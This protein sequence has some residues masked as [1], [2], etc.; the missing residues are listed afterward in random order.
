MSQFTLHRNPNPSTR[1]DIPLLL[2]VQADLLEALATRVV[3]P[4]YRPEAAGPGL[5]ARLTPVVRFQER[6]W[7][8]MIPELAGVPRT[9]LGPAVGDLAGARTDLLR[10][11]DL[12]LTGF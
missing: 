7:I 4:L 12:L 3:V 9:A 1:K 5:M 10:A 6:D 11:L 2:D 8:A